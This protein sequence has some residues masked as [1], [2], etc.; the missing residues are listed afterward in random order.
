MRRRDFITLLGGAAAWPFAAR[1]QQR[2]APTIGFVHGVAAEVS[3]SYSYAPAFRKGLAEGGYVEGENVAVEYH[4]LGGQ[5]GRLPSLM[6]DLVRRRPAL[7]VTGGSP[8]AL[9]AKTATATIP[10]VFSVAEDPVQMGLVANLARPSG[11]ATGINFLG[12]EIAPKRLGLLHDAV[13]TA[14][15]IGV[16]VNPA[17]PGVTETTLHDLPDAARALGLQIRVLKAASVRE[18]EAAFADLAR[19][20]VDALFVGN[21]PLIGSRVVQIVV[22]ATRHGIPAVYP[23]REYVEAGG[24]MS[25]GTEFAGVYRQAGGYAARIL[26]GAKPGDLPVLQSSK[27]EFVINLATARALGLTIPGDVLSIADEVIE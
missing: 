22:L 12:A 5:Y 10:I 4:W 23:N 26:K 27:F 15:R 8:V 19:D 11:N 16:L 18:I 3:A 25:Y 17:N 2:A 24:L 21:D 20:P 9:A 14:V 6:A 1:A 7:I 13:P